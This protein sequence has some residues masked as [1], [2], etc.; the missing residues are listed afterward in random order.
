MSALILLV[1]DEAAISLPLSDRLKKAGYQ[2]EVEAD[3]Q[4]AY[5]KALAGS[6]NLI[7]LD[8]QLPGKSGLDV[9]RDLRENGVQTPILMLTAFGEISDKVLGLRTGADDY[10]AKPFDMA[11]LLAR[12]EALLRRMQPPTPAKVLH[13]GRLQIDQVK[14]VVKLNGALVTL[15]AREFQLLSY[16]A[17]RPG[18]LVSREELL[19]QVWGYDSNMNTR[20]V[21]VHVGW[22]RQKLEEDP[23]K[24]AMF[25]TRIGLGY[26]FEPPV[27]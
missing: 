17:A 13:F 15:S 8:L 14:A 25:L 16:F 4:R 27:G 10:M 2:V 7:L 11:E 20:T 26:Q 9:C 1:E 23:K 21:D 12:V 24:P 6:Y 18:Q 22:L 3:G 5:D 19:S